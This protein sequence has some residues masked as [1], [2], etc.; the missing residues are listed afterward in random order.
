MRIEVKMGNVDKA[1]KV[2]KKKIHE[3][4]RFQVLREKEFYQSKGE[5][6]RREKSAGTLRTKK[7]LA[8]NNRPQS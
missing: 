7:R 4:G 1:L 2:L 5:K 6:Q 3:D 8:S